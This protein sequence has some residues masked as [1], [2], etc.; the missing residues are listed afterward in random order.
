[1][2]YQQEVERLSLETIQLRRELDSACRQVSEK[3]SILTCA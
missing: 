3:E 1:M 2:E